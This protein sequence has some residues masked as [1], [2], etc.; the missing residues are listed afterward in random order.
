M[1]FVPRPGSAPWV[2]AGASV[3]AAL[4]GIGAAWAAVRV[5]L[6]PG[7]FVLLLLALTAL[8][9]ATVGWLYTMGFQSLTYYLDRNG[10]VVQLG[11]WR[12]PISMD[13]IEGI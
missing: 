5:P 12:L 3:A 10:L 1:T 13:A 2:L 8:V 7:A 11:P 9:L 6:G 4:L